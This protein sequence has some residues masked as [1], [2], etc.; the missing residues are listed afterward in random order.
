[1]IAMVSPDPMSL[2]QQT[3]SPKDNNY[4]II[5]AEQKVFTPPHEA[6]ADMS[7]YGEGDEV[8]NGEV[9]GG[10]AITDRL[11]AAG[12]KRKSVK[13]KTANVGGTIRA[14]SPSRKDIARTRA[15]KKQIRDEQEK[16]R[17]VQKRKMLHT[18]EVASS[19]DHHTF[20]G[21]NDSRDLLAVNSRHN[22]SKICKLGHFFFAKLPSL[23]RP[24][25]RV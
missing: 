2:S 23:L 3:F 17:N 1:M 14:K 16:A 12:L 24:Q 6:Q 18:Y 20:M 4:D 11:K 19:E 13:G 21:L 15:L 5:H 10:V 9:K 8:D 7:D 25:Y 22:R